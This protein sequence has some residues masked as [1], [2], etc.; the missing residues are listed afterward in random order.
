MTDTNLFTLLHDRVMQDQTLS[1]QEKKSTYWFQQYQRAIEKISSPTRLSFDYLRQNS[2]DKQVLP[3]N[4]V[5]RGHLYFFR[6]QAEN[7]RPGDYYD[8]LPFVLVTNILSN[9]FAGI[10]FH[11]LPYRQ[12]AI[13]MD[14]LV[15]TQIVNS[16]NSLQS[17]IDVT[18]HELKNIDKYQ[19]YRGCYRSYRVSRMQSPLLQIGKTQWATALFLPVELFRGASNTVVWNK[20]QRRIA[21]EV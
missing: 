9:G 8:A 15:Q 10:N 7:R 11:Y 17:K 3:G 13:F 14:A 20:T 12:R 1:N 19:L 6:Y 2:S 5:R 21:R 4:A 16:L 18:P